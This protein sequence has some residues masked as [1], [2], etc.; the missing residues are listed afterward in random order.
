M[1][2]ICGEG[3]DVHNARG[4]V[5]FAMELSRPRI[6]R[7]FTKYALTATYMYESDPYLD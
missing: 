5:Y 3:L 2:K 7:S 1:I 4:Q 6:V